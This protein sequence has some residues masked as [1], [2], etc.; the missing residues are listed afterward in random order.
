MSHTISTRA[1]Q[2]VG[3]ERCVSNLDASVS[4]YCK[5]LG[6]E[7]K[8]RDAG[9]ASLRLGMESIRLIA[10][11]VAPT[12]SGVGFHHIAIVT[13]DMDAAYRRLQAFGCS[14]IS[15]DG[16]QQLPP[17]SGG[18][19]AFK[20]RDPDGHPLEL[21]AFPR[22]SHDDSHLRWKEMSA[23]A[24]TL[25]I[26]HSAIVVS[27]ADASI[28]FYERVLGLKQTSRQTNRGVEQGLL[29]GVD[30]AVVDVVGLSMPTRNTPHVELLCYERPAKW[31]ERA[32]IRIEWADRMV[33]L[34]DRIDG[35]ERM[36][37]Q[38]PDGY[39]IE[40]VTQTL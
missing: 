34:V 40:L 16:Y 31:H 5:A 33:F 38:D 36:S 19:E 37:L 22:A 39:P 9:S 13:D 29:D 20:F 35:R 10:G 24:L 25:G 23:S 30:E 12:L 32:N 11:Q 18:V 28:A 7:V 6:F 21:I 27:D 1:L 4:F 15:R 8:K 17:S 14:P 3:F 2:F 26:D